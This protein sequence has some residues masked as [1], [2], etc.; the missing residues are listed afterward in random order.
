M[1]QYREAAAVVVAALVFFACSAPASAQD[2]TVSFLP[3]AT[4]TKFSNVSLVCALTALALTPGC[5]RRLQLWG[6]RA[7]AWPCCQLCRPPTR[8]T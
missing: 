7:D 8:R 5:V 6:R 2:S 3:S 4:P 1:G